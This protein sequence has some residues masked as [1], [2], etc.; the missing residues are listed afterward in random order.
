MTAKKSVNWY[1][2]KKYRLGACV[3]RENSGKLTQVATRLEFYHTNY[4]LNFMRETAV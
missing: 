3:I 1:Q 4:H 2:R